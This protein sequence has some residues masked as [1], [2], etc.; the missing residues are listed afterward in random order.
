MCTGITLTAENGDVVYGRTLEWGAFDIDS[1]VMIVPRGHTLTATMEDGDPGMKWETKHGFVGINGLS[2]TIALDGLNEKGLA[3]GA[4]YHPGFASYQCFDPATRDKSLGPLDIA[5]YLLSQFATMEEA[6]DGIRDVR[7]VP[8]FEEALENEAA[9]PLHLIV[10]DKS[11]PTAAI[12][13]EYLDGELTIF[14]APL[15]V[16][17]N[18]PTYDWHITNLRNYVN[19]SAVDIPTKNVNE[20]DFSPLGAGSGML[21]LP[22]DFTPPSR[23]IRAVA[24][25]AT[26]RATTTG[27]ETMYE[28]F[29]I[30]DNFNVPPHAVEGSNIDDGNTSDLRSATL[31]TTVIDTKNL[32][33][34]YHTMHNR[35]VRM[36]DLTAIDFKGLENVTFLPLDEEKDQDIKTVV[37][38]PR[39]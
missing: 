20:I 5:N 25:S 32:I 27:K 12:V 3:V 16:L 4:F 22:G 15:G 8:V 26:A 33:L 10:T 24:F 38:S 39:E 36:L 6:R 11:Q 31:W 17:T 28:I 19:L 37:L 7:V 13:I 30:L 18:S 23:F 35:R 2:K 29:R 34:Y 1:Q 21:G 14:D 9:P